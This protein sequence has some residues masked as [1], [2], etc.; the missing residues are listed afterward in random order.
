MQGWFSF[1]WMLLGHFSLSP[2]LLESAVL[3]WALC[4]SSRVSP[5]SE[6][7]TIVRSRWEGE[8][9]SEERERHAGE[10]ENP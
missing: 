7:R 2:D 3:S 1:S 4:T 10:G 9:L 8:T 6:S 5:I